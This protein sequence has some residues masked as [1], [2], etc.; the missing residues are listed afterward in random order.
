[1]VT[2]GAVGAPHGSCFFS[3]STR[4]GIAIEYEYRFTEYRFTEYRF[5]EY[6][7]DE[8]RCDARS[9]FKSTRSSSQN[10]GPTSRTVGPGRTSRTLGVL[11]DGTP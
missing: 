4:F 11:A 3:Y 7:Y 8:I 10:L 1:V 2:D 9:S 6:E 5:T